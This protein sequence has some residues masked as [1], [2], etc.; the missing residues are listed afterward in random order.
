M[1]RQQRRASKAKSDKYEAVPICVCGPIPPDRHGLATG[2]GA[3]TIALREFGKKICEVA[4]Q[5]LAN[6]K[7]VL[8]M[9]FCL[10]DGSGKLFEIVAFPDSA[11]EDKDVVAAFIRR[12]IQRRRIVRYAIAFE[13]WRSP[14]GHWPPSEDFDREEVVGVLVEDRAGENLVTFAKVAGSDE[15]RHLGEFGEWRTAP[16]FGRF[17]RMFEVMPAR[18]R[19]SSELPDDVGTVF[20]AMSTAYSVVVLGRRGPTGELFVGRVSRPEDDLTLMQLADRV[21]RELPWVELVTGP[22]ADQL[23]A[24]VMAQWTPHREDQERTVN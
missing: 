11:K 18:V 1:N 15:K 3:S 13:G 23:L 20:V 24:R 9:L 21:R 19:P 2:A 7:S 10:L 4:H 6:S 22:E 17:V 16:G 8:P 12:E 5:S 14:D